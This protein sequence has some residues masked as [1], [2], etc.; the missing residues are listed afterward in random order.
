MVWNFISK[1][2][3]K[4]NIYFIYFILKHAFIIKKYI[5]IEQFYWTVYDWPLR[6]T[7]Y[8]VTSNSKK[9]KLQTA[10]YVAF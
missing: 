5:G 8:N 2:K 6:A 7:M 9:K 10:L 1:K 3:E 4:K